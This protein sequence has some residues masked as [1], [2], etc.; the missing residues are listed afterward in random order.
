VVER[1][2]HD[3]LDAVLDGRTPTIDD[4]ANLPFTASVFDEALRLYPPAAAF[5]RRPVRAVELGGY[6]IPKMTSIFVSPYITQRNPRYFVA[7]QT[8]IPGR[9]GA[10]PAE[11][12][13]YFPFGGGSKMCIG[14]PFARL[15]AT[16]AIATIAGRYA[17]R[18]NDETPIEPA[19][20]AVMRP[21]RP[22]L[23]TAVR[24]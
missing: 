19:A 7:P 24:R 13:A 2:L 17:L 1:H 21:A 14:E 10:P 6:E 15:E 20:Q 4:V 3:E 11:R 5:A 16:L 12:F 8:F 23:V 22:V 9:W 18:R